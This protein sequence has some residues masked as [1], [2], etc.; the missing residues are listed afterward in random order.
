[1]VNNRRLLDAITG[2][3]HEQWF[4]SFCLKSLPNLKMNYLYVRSK[5]VVA[6][7]LVR[8]VCATLLHP[9]LCCHTSNIILWFF[10]YLR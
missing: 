7:T 5:S 1:M 8:C 9:S 3:S 4:Y 6:F 10:T 2:H